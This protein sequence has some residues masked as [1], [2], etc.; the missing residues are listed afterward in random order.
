MGWILVKCIFDGR[1]LYRGEQFAF[2]ADYALNHELSLWA[3]ETLSYKAGF[4]YPV[5]SVLFRVWLADLGFHVGGAIWVSLMVLSLLACF[6]LLPRLLNLSTHPYR[7]P[8]TCFG[9]LIASYFIQ[10]DLHLMN[11]NSIYLALLLAGLYFLKNEK[12][13]WGGLLYAASIAVKFYSVL[14]L[15]YFLIRR[16]FSF[17]VVVSLWLVFFYIVTPIWVMGFDKAF[18]LTECWVLTIFDSFEPD[19]LLRV[20]AGWMSINAAL[21]EFL[22]A[23][24]RFDLNVMDISKDAIFKIASATKAL[25]LVLFSLY[26]FWDSRRP[27]EK[28]SSQDVFYVGLFSLIVVFLSST[29]QPHH[30]VV[31]LIPATFLAKAIFDSSF[32]STYRWG[33]SLILAFFYVLLYH[34]LPEDGPVERL[35]ALFYIVFLAFLSFSLSCKTFKKNL[36]T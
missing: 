2:G 36:S 10:S 23:A 13:G 35:G 25:W 8:I 18:Q 33:I 15:P 7:Y 4:V 17:V 1:R 31:F 9:F 16:K 5:P 6:W 27:K 12:V 21:L 3:F 28:D 26:F 20:R 24:G 34:L 14:F 22:S 29:A 32:K 30:G 19:F 11:S